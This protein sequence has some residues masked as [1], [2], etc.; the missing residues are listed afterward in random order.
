MHVA[1]ET[2]LESPQA[3]LPEKFRNPELISEIRREYGLDSKNFSMVLTDYD[4]RPNVRTLIFSFFTVT[5]KDYQIKG[6]LLV[7]LA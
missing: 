1:F 7:V 5:L 6:I 2:D 3:S 4:L